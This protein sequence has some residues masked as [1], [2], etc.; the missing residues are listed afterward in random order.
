[1]RIFTEIERKK[2]YELWQTNQPVSCIAE[3]TGASAVRCIG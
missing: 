3:L 2:I 1:M